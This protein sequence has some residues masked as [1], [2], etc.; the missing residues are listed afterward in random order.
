M[1]DIPAFPYALLWGERCLRSVA[2]LTRED[3]AQFL[4]FAAQTPLRTRTVRYPLAQANRALADLRS[5]ELSGAA[6]LFP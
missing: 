1:S 3:A 2:N 4:A 6:V 5:G